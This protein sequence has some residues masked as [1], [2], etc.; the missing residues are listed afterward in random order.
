MAGIGD[1]SLELVA[2]FI[3][4]TV[5]TSSTTQIVSTEGTVAFRNASFHKVDLE[6]VGTQVDNAES[7]D[8]ENVI[9]W[10]QE[11]G[12]TGAKVSWWGSVIAACY[13][14]VRIHTYSAKF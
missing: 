6:R 14:A 13:N 3:I 11:S 5:S 9:A 8:K 1:T 7:V 4:A 12:D 10:L 2:S